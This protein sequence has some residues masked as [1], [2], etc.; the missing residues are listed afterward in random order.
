MEY[1]LSLGEWSSV[2]AIPCSVV[3]KYLCSSNEI[4]LKVLLWVLRNSK[5]NIN[6]NNACNN[7]K[8]TPEEFDNAFLYWN[9]LGVF[10]SNSNTLEIAVKSSEMK[11]YT[12]DDSRNKKSFSKYQRPESSHIISR[13]KESKDISYLINEAQLILGRPI[14]SIDSTILIMLHDNEGLPIDVILMLLQYS[15]SIGK[16]HIRYIEQ[17]GMNWASCGIDTIEKAEKKIYSM[18]HFS[19]LWRRFRK[20]VGIDA[21][22]ATSFEEEIIL[23]W[24]DKWKLSDELI[25]YAYE[26]CIGR[27]GKYSFRYMDGILKQ[28]YS[29]GICSVEQVRQIQTRSKSMNSENSSTSYDINEY[30]DYLKDWYDTGILNNIDK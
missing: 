18:D 14:S 28:W 5:D 3:D 22:N 17:I 21:R 1:K 11:N 2:F 29:Q 6:L 25:K 26:I 20:L 7:L 10:G 4:Q 19:N 27:Q 30:E 12:N 15:V 13:I 8:I 16:F 9:K 24:Y 23:K